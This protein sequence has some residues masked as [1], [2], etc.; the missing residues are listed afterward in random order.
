MP[1]VSEAKII[2]KTHTDNDNWQNS[3]NTGNWQEK[4]QTELAH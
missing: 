2:P 4:Y 1:K 3:A